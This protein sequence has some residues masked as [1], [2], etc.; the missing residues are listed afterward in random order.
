MGNCPCISLNVSPGE[1]TSQAVSCTS[2][3]AAVCCAMAGACMYHVGQRVLHSCLLDS[4]ARAL[5][6]ATVGD[7]KKSGRNFK[8]TLAYDDAQDDGSSGIEGVPEKDIR[9]DPAVPQGVQRQA[10]IVAHRPFAGGGETLGGKRTD[11]QHE[12]R[13]WWS[14]PSGATTRRCTT[15]ACY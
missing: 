3:P 4:G 13:L 15:L 14:P 8:Y 12:L 10:A 1:T 7:V 9:P 2:E 11:R 5:Y 6:K